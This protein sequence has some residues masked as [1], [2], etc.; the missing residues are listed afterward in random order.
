MKDIIPVFIVFA[1]IGLILGLTVYSNK[2]YPSNR[3]LPI[4]SG[5]EM[6]GLTATITHPDTCI[7]YIQSDTIYIKRLTK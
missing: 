3:S 5:D 1:V 4:N 6:V 7:A 2:S